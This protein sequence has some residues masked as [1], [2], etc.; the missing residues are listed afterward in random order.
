M[1]YTY[2][3]ATDQS[4]QATFSVCLFSEFRF[5]MAD[6]GAVTQDTHYTA[7]ITREDCQDCLDTDP[8]AS[9]TFCRRE[10]LLFG[11]VDPHERCDK[12]IAQCLLCMSCIR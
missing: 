10:W 2:D 3:T 4:A 11:R 5:N 12:H 9:P 6:V 8:L 1:L 7:N